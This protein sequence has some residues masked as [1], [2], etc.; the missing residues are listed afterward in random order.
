MR[1]DAPGPAASIARASS[2]W[3]PIARL[4]VCQLYL[5]G[6]APE[7]ASIAPNALPIQALVIHLR[8]TLHALATFDQASAQ[9]A[10]SQPDSPFCA[11]M[12]GA[13]AGSAPRLLVAS[14]NDATGTPR[15]TSFKS[16]QVLRR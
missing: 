6:D 9:H 8:T 4:P 11:T 3:G 2:V 5:S 15:P 12:P 16:L 13:G 7:D 14:A 1:T 10:Q